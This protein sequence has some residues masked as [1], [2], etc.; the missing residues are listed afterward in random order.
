M[1][2]FLCSIFVSG[3]VIFLFCK[4]L[5]CMADCREY[6]MNDTICVSVLLYY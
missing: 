6:N 5:L 2:I 1:N 3:V 4:F